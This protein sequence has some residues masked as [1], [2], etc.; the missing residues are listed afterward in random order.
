LAKYRALYRNQGDK[1]RLEARNSRLQFR[2]VVELVPT[3]IIKDLHCVA[4]Y[5]ND[6]CAG[7]FRD[8]SAEIGVSP[9][10]ILPKST[11]IIAHS[12]GVQA[13]L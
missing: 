7:Q 4:I 13:S 6:P 3:V 11:L 1:D 2:R 10:T 5:G 12:I 8:C 9:G